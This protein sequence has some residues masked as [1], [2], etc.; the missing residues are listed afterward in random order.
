MR[1]TQ[2]NSAKNWMFTNVT[3]NW[4]SASTRWLVNQYDFDRKTDG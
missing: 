1:E 3:W 2:A 4:F